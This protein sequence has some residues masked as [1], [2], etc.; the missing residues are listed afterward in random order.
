ML[1]FG[2]WGSVG[3]QNPIENFQLCHNT[4]NKNTPHLLLLATQ[5]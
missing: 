3:N 1:T 5:F 2:V 4:A